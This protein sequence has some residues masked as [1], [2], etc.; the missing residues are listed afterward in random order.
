MHQNYV[1][2]DTEKDPFILSVVVTDANN[3]NV[4]QYRAVLW[5]KNVSQ[6]VLTLSYDNHYWNLPIVFVGLQSATFPSISNYAT[7]YFLTITI[8]C[9]RKFVRIRTPCPIPSPPKITLIVSQKHHTCA[10]P[11]GMGGGGVWGI[12]K[13]AGG[14]SEGLSSV[15]L[16]WKLSSRFTHDTKRHPTPILGFHIPN[17]F[18]IFA[19]RTRSAPETDYVKYCFL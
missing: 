2:I 13:F 8:S 14:G 12:F 3:H 11:A 5:R 4:P 15:I 18:W 6:I 9:R 7:V 10:D 1:G 16:L 19:M 17:T